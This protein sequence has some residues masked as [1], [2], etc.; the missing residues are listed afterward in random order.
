MSVFLVD[1]LDKK[2]DF[3]VNFWNWRAIVEA[4]GSLG[5]VPEDR[6]QELHRQYCG[7]GLTKEEAR[8]VAA[9]LRAK[10]L[11]ALGKDER[12]LLDGTK[13]S[14]PDDSKMH[15]TETEKNYSTNAEVLGEF[16]EFCETCEGFDV[17]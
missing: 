2:K 4:V 5:V 6:V 14:K 9:A 12:L 10:L 11:P 13:T 17:N 3:N 7:T 16:A 15:Y 8:K 1:R